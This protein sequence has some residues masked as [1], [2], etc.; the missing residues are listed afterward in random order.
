MVRC[1]P[2]QGNGKGFAEAFKVLKYSDLHPDQRKVVVEYMRGKDVFLPAAASRPAIAFYLLLL[3]FTFCFRQYEIP[4]DCIG[5]SPLIAYERACVLNVRHLTSP[6]V[7]N[8]SK[9]A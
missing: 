1:S 2:L 3:H 6:S 7:Q 4:L 5:V 8:S 9:Y